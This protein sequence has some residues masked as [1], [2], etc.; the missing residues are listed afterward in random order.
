[1]PM[2]NTNGVKILAM[3]CLLKHLYRV[4]PFLNVNACIH[5]KCLHI[6][7]ICPWLLDITSIFFDIIE[8]ILKLFVYVV[9]DHG[10]N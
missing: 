8:I 5:L 10:L 9:V 1:M 6:S 3:H 4:M 7:I 2:N